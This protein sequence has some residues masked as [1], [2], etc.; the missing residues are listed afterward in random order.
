MAS[1]SCS[2]PLLSSLE[3]EIHV[4]MTGSSLESSKTSSD[5]SFEDKSVSGPQV[6]EQGIEDR[7]TTKEEPSFTAQERAMKGS[8]VDMIGGVAGA[9]SLG[10]SC[11]SNSL[12]RSRDLSRNRGGLPSN[13]SL[14]L[15]TFLSRNRLKQ[16]DQGLGRSSLYSSSRSRSK[17][18]LTHRVINKDGLKINL[19]KDC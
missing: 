12:L 18:L 11:G 16:R 19:R 3:S 4:F 13:N 2:S 9:F 7:V 1:G 15:G 10:C 17:N 14:S 6:V 8:L 5:P